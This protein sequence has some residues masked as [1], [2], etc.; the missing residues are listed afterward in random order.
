M[1]DTC[2]Y[3]E[4]LFDSHWRSLSLRN[5]C[6]SFCKLLP[7]NPTNYAAA[8]SRNYNEVQG[9]EELGGIGCLNIQE[10]P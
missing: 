5:F 9:V 2:Q 4:G 8:D 7:E 1:C 6:I 3:V 10:Y